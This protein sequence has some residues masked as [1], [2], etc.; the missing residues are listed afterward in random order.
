MKIVSDVQFHPAPPWVELELLT[1]AYQIPWSALE[2][3]FI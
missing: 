1:Q 3:P 2:V